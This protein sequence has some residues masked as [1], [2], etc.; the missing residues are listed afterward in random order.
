MADVRGSGDEI[1]AI[2]ERYERRK[3]AAVAALYPAFSPFQHFSRAEREFWYGTYLS[4]RFGDT[5]ELTVLEIG[6][7]GGDNILFLR[8][9][10]IPREL[11]FANELLD[12]RVERLKEW[13]SPENILAGD[14]RSLEL[15]MQ[16]DVVLQSTV[17]SS[18]LD[19]GVRTQLAEKM[20][21][22][23]KPGG[24]VLWYDF[25]INNPSNRDVRA[26]P[27]SEVRRLFPG[28]LSWTRRKVTLAPP[29][30]RR[31]GRGYNFLNCP[32]LR[33]HTVAVI[34]KA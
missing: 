13:L 2:R 15:S 34:R 4:E 33:S 1:Q 23:L 8:R 19:A 7:G 6:A 14:A 27:W 12:E 25:H 30:G 18:I 16:F 9:F 20:W 26:V 17:F 10:G 22:L 11:I 28:A 5:K 31:V 3:T 32:L 21:M 29:I 24:V